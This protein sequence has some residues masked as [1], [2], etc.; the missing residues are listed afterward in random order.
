MISCL[1]SH[2]NRLDFTDFGSLGVGTVVPPLL[3]KMRCCAIESA[4]IH[5]FCIK[6]PELINCPDERLKSYVLWKFQEKANKF[7]PG[8][9]LRKGVSYGSSDFLQRD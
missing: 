3:E 5:L 6:C 8:K 9:N 2:G 1:S 7:L 4:A